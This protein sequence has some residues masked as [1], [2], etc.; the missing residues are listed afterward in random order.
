MVDTGHYCF[1]ASIHLFVRLDWHLKNHCTKKMQAVK[2]MGTNQ[3]KNDKIPILNGWMAANILCFYFIFNLSIFSCDDWGLWGNS[4]NSALFINGQCVSVDS[5]LT[6]I[7][8]GVSLIILTLSI[9]ICCQA[10]SK[11]EQEDDFRYKLL[12]TKKIT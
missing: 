11:K 9:I 12:N 5:L 7:I 6:I 10:C 4:G 2:L 3:C 8:G 1:R